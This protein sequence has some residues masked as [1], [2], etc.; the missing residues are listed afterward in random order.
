MV[1]QI[2]SVE[3][4]ATQLYERKLTMIR[5]YLLAAAVIVPLAPALAAA[6]SAA[7]G[8]SAQGAGGDAA[9]ACL[10]DAQ[11][12]EHTITMQMSGYGDNAKRESA[13]VH[14]SMAE[15]AARAGDAQHCRDLMTW[16]G[17]DW[18]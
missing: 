9:A 7:P 8:Q 17:E 11:T 4:A 13:K 3:L 18:R 6:Q 1:A 16:A 5:G 14:L 10:K 2:S 15:Q 12:A